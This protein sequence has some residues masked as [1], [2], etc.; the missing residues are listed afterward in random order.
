M[1]GR[2]PFSF[3]FVLVGEKS[4]TVASNEKGDTMLRKVHRS[5]GFGA[6]DQAAR[7]AGY[8]HLSR[9]EGPRRIRPTVSSHSHH[10]SGV[11]EMRMV[12]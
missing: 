9:G 7:D 6:P 5:F 2:P 4:P 8:C 3:N 11:S 10:G 12:W 1:V